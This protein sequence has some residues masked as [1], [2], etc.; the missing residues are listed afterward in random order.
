M[1]HDISQWK[2]FPSKMPCRQKVIYDLFTSLWLFGS[3]ITLRTCSTWKQLQH[4]HEDFH[5]VAAQWIFNL[6][7][8]HFQR[9]ILQVLKPFWRCLSFS[10]DFSTQN[11]NSKKFKKT[12]LTSS[13][14]DPKMMIRFSQILT[15]FLTKRFTNLHL[16]SIS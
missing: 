5:K 1:N 16:L 15:K 7:F 9:K 4:F 13:S 6:N 11:V 2:L 8:S 12:R 10:H 14:V 3:S